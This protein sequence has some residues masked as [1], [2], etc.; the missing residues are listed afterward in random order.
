MKHL[1][2]PLFARA[3]AATSL[4][5]PLLLSTNVRAETT[6]THRAAEI[7]TYAA[8]KRETR[9]DLRLVPEA[10]PS[11]PT[12]R[13]DN[14]VGT[15]LGLIGIP[16][17]WGGNTPESGMDCS[18]FVRYVFNKVLGV[19]LPRRSAAIS[20]ATVSISTAEL[21]PGDLVFFQTTQE[22]F[23]HVGIYIGEHKFVH[24]PSTGSTI[25]V[26]DLQNAYWHRRFSGARRIEAA[27]T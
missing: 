5:I 27:L 25:R 2:V 18:G 13:R 11:E 24:A 14:L 4:A 26:D 12:E 1:N 20:R 19:E 22:M 10:F 23:S 16:Y 7:D 15:A 8:S 6:L 3:V 9:Y 17:Q 21:R